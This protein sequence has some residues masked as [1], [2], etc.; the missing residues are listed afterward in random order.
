MPHPFVVTGDAPVLRNPAQPVPKEMFKSKE[1][2]RITA[3]MLEALRG[4]PHGVAIAAPQVGEPYQIFAVRGFVMKNMERSDDEG[5]VVFINP[6]ITRVSKKKELMEEGCLSI[7]GVYGRVSRSTKA[8]VRAQDET[9]KKFERGG[10]DLLAQIF[11]HEV[12][13]LT[14]TLFIDHNPTDLRTAE[15]THDEA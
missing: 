6:K 7:P 5:D 1:L 8:T 15:L 9:G 12:D 13:H 10:S 14:G 4:E 3:R 11:Q 2:A